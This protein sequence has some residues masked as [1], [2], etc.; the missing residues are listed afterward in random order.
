MSVR[1]ETHDPAQYKVTTLLKL[2]KVFKK[3]T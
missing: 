3:K 2:E 1:K